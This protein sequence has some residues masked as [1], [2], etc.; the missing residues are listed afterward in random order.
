MMHP[1]RL[2]IVEDSAPI[3]LALQ[4]SLWGELGFA[5]DHA[6]DYATA[7]RLVER[8]PTRYFLSILDLSLPD[9]PHGEIVD[10]A[11]EKRVPA[12]VYTSQEDRRLRQKLL[13]KN[14]IDYVFKNNQGIETLTRLVRR[15]HRNCTVRVLVVDDSA[16]QRRLIRSMLKTYMFNVHVA[17]GA[18]NALAILAKNEDISLVI[19]DFE[20]EG[21]DGVQ[22]CKK[23]REFR[24]RQ[25]LAIIG[26]SSTDDEFLPV[27]FIKNG[28]N[29]FLKKPFQRE[30]FYHR[31]VGN[32]ETIETFRKLQD[33]NELKN[34]FLGIAA[35]DL[36]NPINGIKGFSEILADELAAAGS[37]DHAE[38]A[39]ML[40][41]A[42][43]QMLQLVNDLLDI[44]VIESG[45]LD[46]KSA[47]ADLAE[48]IRERV[49][50][51][52][53]TAAS[54]HVTIEAQL[55]PRMEVVCDGHRI[56]QVV[57]NLLSNA[58]KFSPSG[59]TVTISARRN[60][61]MAEVSVQDQ[62]PGIP[63]DQQHRLFK[64][65]SKLDAPSAAGE[66]STGLGL[67][68]VKKIVETHRGRAWVSSS[69]GRGAC[70]SFSL[71]MT[72]TAPGGTD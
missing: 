21:L 66:Q 70:F 33:L 43:T 17:S 1:P 8:S 46:L 18:E 61:D 6:P 4:E 50:I 22:L 24:D 59:C 63:E 13:A 65:F 2:L 5:V 7:A 36:R 47:S 40:H 64:T 51:V 12:I 30:E 41:M 42:S 14:I 31:V 37:D 53:I 52:A 23:I 19:T 62:G 28:A 71:P 15:L 25:S 45:R 68:I 55:P 49:R 38:I 20:M 16:P 58:V 32:Q 69:Q 67:S 34:R 54:R 11:L 35:H 39:R 60:G 9:A 44:S 3:A 10:F 57:D 48:L 27:R 26:M 29:D 56:A 72:G